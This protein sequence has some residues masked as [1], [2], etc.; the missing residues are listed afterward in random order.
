MKNI[1][2]L[3][4]FWF[5][6][7]GCSGL[8]G[9]SSQY[10]SGWPVLL[11]DNSQSNCLQ[12]AGVFKNDGRFSQNRYDYKPFVPL[13]RFFFDNEI[14]S[15][16]DRRS[17]NLRW[18]TPSRLYVEAEVNS[19]VVSKILDSGVGDFVCKDGALWLRHEIDKVGEGVGGYRAETSIGFRISFSGEL[20]G[21]EKLS[22]MGLFLWIIPVWG[23]QTFW[24]SWIPLVQESDAGIHSGTLGDVGQ[25]LGVT[26][27]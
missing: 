2:A 12:I 3:S 21:E 18:E 20:V 25:G 17:V 14:G 23:Y 22:S 11:S 16:A 19:Q 15:A 13:N 24:Y 9:I 27:Y 7:T 26:H 1:F 10:P 8:T 4:V 5:F 6:V